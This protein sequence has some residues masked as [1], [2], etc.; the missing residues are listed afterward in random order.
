MG[1]SM[2]IQKLLLGILLTASI[3][4]CGISASISLGTLLGQADAV[5]VATVRDG[6]AAAQI[7]S[8]DLIVARTVK[9]SASTGS[10]ISAMLSSP[11]VINPGRGDGLLRMNGAIVA[12]ELVGKTGLWFLQQSG[13]GWTV[14][15]R[16]GG[17]ISTWDLYV[18]LPSGNLP[19]T[20]AYDASA[21][22]KARLIQEIGA[23]AQNPSTA[24]AISRLEAMRMFADL[25]YDFQPVLRQLTSSP[26]MG[27]RAMGLAGQIRLG[28]PG[29]LNAVVDSNL[30]TFPEDAQN[31]LANAVCE[32]RNTDVSGVAALGT[33]LGSQYA[34]SMRVCATYAL[35]EIHSRETLP[36]LEKLLDDSSAQIRYDAVIGIA[37]FAIAFPMVGMA[38]KPAAIAT[39][40]P[41][42]SVTNEMRQH[43]PA[44]GLFLK[45]E[46]EYISYW[47]TWL[48]AHPVQ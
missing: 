8:L 33:L 12:K 19:P 17:D 9:G 34:D 44:Q 25:G 20:F 22:P 6:S 5:V 32:Y 28:S 27:T 40:T 2:R 37:Q 36:L 13:S 11:N 15:P 48:A 10:S 21:T 47:K 39:F 18:P 4:F 45:N 24:A 35:R 31:Q 46:Q 1:V 26:Q 38:E 14:L 30:A 3:G 7:L 29:A 43:Y 16:A 41:P 42:P 23:A